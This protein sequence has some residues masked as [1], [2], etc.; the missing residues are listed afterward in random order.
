MHV[1]IQRTAFGVLTLLSLASAAAAQ[2]PAPSA[3]SAQPA[4]A[5]A[6]G[7]PRRP[8]LFFREEWKQNEKNDEHPASAASLANPSLEMTMHGP[9]KDI[10]LTGRAGD[11]NNPIHLW[12]GN[13]TSP[14]AVSLREKNN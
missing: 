12:S 6:G 10:Q 13:C 5:R 2:A 3:Q 14:C 1:N 11:E 4:A 7:P 8:A 9:G